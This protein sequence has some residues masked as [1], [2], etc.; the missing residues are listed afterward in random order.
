MRPRY[1]IPLVF[2]LLLVPGLLGNS[3]KADSEKGSFT[4]FHPGQAK[5]PQRQH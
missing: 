5:R 2:V 3:L 1:F 4:K